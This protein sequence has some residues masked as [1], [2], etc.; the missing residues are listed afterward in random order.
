MKSRDL[1]YSSSIV[2][3][4]FLCCI[5]HNPVTALIRVVVGVV[6][7]IIL[8]GVLYCLL[9]F[10]SPTQLSDTERW[11]VII[12]SSTITAVMIP[13]LL[14][15]VGISITATTLALSMDGLCAVLI[16][17]LFF[18][19]HVMLDT[20]F[21][22]MDILRSPAAWG[23]ALIVLVTSVIVAVTV[24]QNVTPLPAFYVTNGDNK[25]S[26][27]PYQLERGGTFRVVLHIDN[28][29]RQALN[30]M[31]QISD[32]RQMLFDKVVKL[33]PQEDIAIPYVLPTNTLVQ[34]NEVTF[35]L[36]SGRQTRT[37]WLRYSVVQQN[38]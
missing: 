18:K 38:E 9:L 23:Y 7:T 25:L 24:R 31:V 29:S 27:Y 17:V 12:V 36:H 30:G 5:F 14:A 10:P 22:N 13:F 21:H 26:D 6:L 19:R 2:L 16:I 4:D 1:V 11:G 20:D 33:E 15:S 28:P 32:S 3:I 8:P 37:L 35:T 34:D